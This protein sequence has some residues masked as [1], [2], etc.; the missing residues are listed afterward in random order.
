M[1]KIILLI[2]TIVSIHT[3][4]QDVVMQNGTINACSGI[5]TDSGGEFENYSN[6]ES[7][8]L[9]ICPEEIGQFVQLSFTSFGTQLGADSMTIYNGDNIASPSL[10]VFSGANNPGLI[11]ANDST[12]SGCLTIEF[13][14]DGIGDT[15]GWSA[16][17]YCFTPCQIITS[18]LDTSTPIPNTDGFIQVCAG[19]DIT[20]SGS[21]NFEIDGVGAT[22]E[23]DLGDGN[24]V[25]GQTATFSYDT[26]GIYV[27][28]LRISDTNTSTHPNGCFNTN[29]INQVIQVSGVPDFTGT[30]A[31]DDTLCFGE[32][33]TIEGIVNPFAVIYNCPP[34]VS[35]TTF[36]PDGSG[37]VYSTCVTVNCFE[38]DEVLID[39]SQLLDICMNI[40]H[41]YS[42][43]LNIKI[44][45]PNGQEAELYSQGGGN[46]YFGGANDDASNIPGIGA[47]YCFS[48]SAT[49]LLAEANTITAG[50][51]PPGDSFEPGT[52]L[53]VE[54]FNALVGSPLN[55]EWCI[56]IIDN[57]AIDN[58]YIFS[59]ELNFDPD[60]PQQDFSFIPSITSQS[61]DPNPSITETNGNTITVAPNA[62]GEYCYIYR[63]VDI[64]GCEFTEEI[65]ITIA[66]EDQP[67]VTYYEDTDGDGYGDTG[68]FIIECSDFPPIGYALN[69]LDCDDTSDTVNPGAPDTE[70]NGV[71]EN[72]DGVDG[73]ALSIED[74]ILANISVFPNP[75]NANITINLPL[76]LTGNKIDINIYDL[77]GRIVYNKSHAI[78]DS[79]ITITSLND[80]AK[81]PYFIKISDNEI[82]FTVIKKL[83]KL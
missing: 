7:F 79:K 28:N 36:L 24:T 21:G 44:I 63:T 81:A 33:T 23:W 26:S 18:Q 15:T 12:S 68:N 20:L 66:D 58:G 4:A 62:S 22:Y 77:N 14:S 10:G 52:Y 5:F 34:P 37:A 30:E 82:G 27:V 3:Y 17:I 2:F 13:I 1:K 19:E 8:V 25:S 16:D 72:C 47:D 43:D 32:T 69:N 61:W 74:Q 35:G 41:S 60:L 65:C 53:P 9:T 57:L 50:F 67:P 42:G 39:A 11:S 51:N 76:G 64:F 46:V 40:E 75:F 70:G 29:L 55:G 71:D 78:V 54:S 6:D 80:L 31:A 48:M 45:S 49:T 38:F 56:E 73:I 83:I 59:W